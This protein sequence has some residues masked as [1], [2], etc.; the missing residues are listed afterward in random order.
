MR[1]RRDFHEVCPSRRAFTLI[2]LLVVVTIIAMLISILLPSMNKSREAARRAVCGSNLHQSG[3]ALV[4]YAM[5]NNKKFPPGNA[6]IS[7][8][9]GIDASFENISKYPMGMGYLATQK[10]LADA[11]IFY[12]PTWS[13]PNSQYDYVDKAG[14][15][16]FGGSPGVYGGWPAPGHAGPSTFWCIAYHYRSTFGG[17]TN[18]VASLTMNSG[19]ALAADHWTRREVLYGPAY[20]HVDG[21]ET[22]FLDGHAAWVGI[23]AEKMDQLEPAAAGITNGSWAFQEL[24]VWQPYFDQ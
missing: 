2:E 11:R 13:H 21:Y 1:L 23:S 6:T 19:V 15:P 22:L 8:G 24:I 4:Q 20:G 3:I 18:G 12:C 7:P 9:Y 16:W 17:S 14:G 5:A 10:Y